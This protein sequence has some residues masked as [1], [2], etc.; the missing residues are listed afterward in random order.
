MKIVVSL[1]AF[2]VTSIVCFAQD[3]V[4]RVLKSDNTTAAEVLNNGN[5]DFNGTVSV[6]AIS[7]GGAISATA[8][9]VSSATGIVSSAAALSAPTNP[10]ASAGLRVRINGTNYIVALYP[11]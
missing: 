3:P 5:A 8:I 10:A 7:S 2:L 11:N 1:V 9:T 6:D 4:W